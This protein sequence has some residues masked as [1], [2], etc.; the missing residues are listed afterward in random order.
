MR[1]HERPVA[2]NQGLALPIDVVVGC[3]YGTSCL[4]R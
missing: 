2:G 4:E 1:E 3:N